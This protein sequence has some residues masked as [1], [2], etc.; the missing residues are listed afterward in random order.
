MKRIFPITACSIILSVL[1]SHANESITLDGAILR[2]DTTLNVK[3]GPG[4]TL[5]K[6][7]LSGSQPLDVQYIT[8]DCNDKNIH[9]RAARAETE[10]GLEKTSA[11]GKRLDEEASFAIAGINGDFFD[12]TSTYPDGTLRP[13]MTTYTTIVDNEIIR[14]SPQGH[15]FII[16]SYGIPAIATLSLDKGFVRCGNNIATIG[17]VNLE[18]I[19]YSGDQAADNAVTIYSSNGWKSPF[20]NQL[21]GNCSEVTVIPADG[22]I[23][24]PS[25]TITARVVSNFSSTGNPDIP[26]DG[27]VLI[28]RGNAKSFIESL[29]IDDLVEIN[30]RFCLPNGDDLIPALAIGGNPRTTVAGESVDSDGTRPDAI[31][32]HPRTGVGISKD[33]KKVIMM[34][35]DG[36][37]QSS[38]VTTRQLGDLLVYAGASE[39]LNFDGGGSSTC[40]TRAMGIVN[41]CSDK[42]GERAVANALYVIADG[43]VKNTDIAEIKFE[44][45]EHKML[46]D[47]YWKP[48]ILAYNSDGILIDSDLDGY[49]LS[50][51]SSIGEIT[52]SGFFHATGKGVGILTAEFNGL[53]ATT[54]ISISAM[55]CES[56]V[57]NISDWSVNGFAVKS[58]VISAF[59]EGFALDYTMGASTNS[60]K[61]TILGK[62][63][64]GSDAEYL[65]IKVHPETS[66]IKNITINLK[67]QGESSLTKIETSDLAVNENHNIDIDLKEV[68][69][70]TSIQPIEFVSMIIT[71]GDSPKSNGRIL[72]PSVCTMS[73]SE[74]GTDKIMIDSTTLEESGH[75]EWFTITGT[76]ISGNNLPS[77]IYIRRYRNKAT[78]VLIN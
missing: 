14:T 64:L 34:V 60:A 29:E 62:Q 12:V 45:Y 18:N 41:N 4:T 9:F 76:K 73:P 74:T 24:N 33:G 67:A 39:G 59:D 65:R 44:S 58:P 43:D 52:S 7:H 72:F 2:I 16:D 51:P 25:K 17:G 53:T 77:G 30:C 15:Q 37:G 20:Q 11:M 71:P 66:H 1:C 27:L 28:G 69:S 19:N 70:D 36:R 42:S 8:V 61:I 57:N 55:K 26:A 50:T 5:T 6:L 38:G 54:T 21:E 35:V 10:T 78:K 49:N 48:K 63:T 22:S 68:V 75:V 32:L 46:P 31:E 56:L 47:S 23:L 40:W 3:I 13:R